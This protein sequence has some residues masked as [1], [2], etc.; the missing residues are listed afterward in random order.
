MHEAN[1]CQTN[2]AVAGSLINDELEPS[3]VNRNCLA[4]HPAELHIGAVSP[5]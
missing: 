1:L 4:V 3:I 5:G 2:R